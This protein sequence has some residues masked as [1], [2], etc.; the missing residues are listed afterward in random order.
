MISPGQDMTRGLVEQLIKAA[1][2]RPA[3]AEQSEAMDFP[4]DRPHRCTRGPRAR[5]DEFAGQIAD[6]AGQKARQMLQTPVDFL[7]AAWEQHYGGALRQTSGENLCHVVAI[8][9]EGG[10]DVVGMIGLS[11]ATA[12]QWLAKLLGGCGPVEADDD[13][14]RELSDLERDLLLD[15]AA[16]FVE[17][18]RTA[19]GNFGGTAFQAARKLGAWPD[20]LGAE[21]AAEYCLLKLAPEQSGQGGLAILLTGPTA[22]LLAGEPAPRA[23]RATGRAAMRAHVD[24]M[25]VEARAMLSASLSVREVMALAPGDVVVLNQPIDEPIDLEVDGRLVLRGHPARQA[26][27]FAIQFAE[28]CSEKKVVGNRE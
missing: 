8:S 7:P 22:A 18:L 26:G 1:R 24:Q 13:E 25:P 4:F 3:R 11:A 5:L 21:D 6:C 17:A 27:Q 23:S 15:I 19:A 10:D 20:A 28:F 12:T 9:V 16:G 2:S 14:A